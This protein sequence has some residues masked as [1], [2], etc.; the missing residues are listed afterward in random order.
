MILLGNPIA[1]LVDAT[2]RWVMLV[3]HTQLG[4]DFWSIGYELCGCRGRADEVE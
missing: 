2:D 1:L 4:T 3:Q